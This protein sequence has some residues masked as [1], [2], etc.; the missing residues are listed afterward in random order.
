L[1]IK[2]ETK[3]GENGGIDKEGCDVFEHELLI[4]KIETGRGAIS[5]FMGWL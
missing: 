4:I 1:Q 5:T 2:S 3:Q